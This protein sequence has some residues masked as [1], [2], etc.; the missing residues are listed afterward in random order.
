MVMTFR[1]ALLT[2]IGI[3]LTYLDPEKAREWPGPDAFLADKWPFSRKDMATG[4]D[5][6]TERTSVRPNAANRRHG[7]STREEK[8]LNKITTGLIGNSSL[9]QDSHCSI[10]KLCAIDSPNPVV[11]ASQ[12]HVTQFS[13]ALIED[14]AI[15]RLLLLTTR[16]LSLRPFFPHSTICMFVQSEENYNNNVNGKSQLEP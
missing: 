8:V 11:V 10:S 14:V 6:R 5:R 3:S 9:S 13:S 12:S 16:P 1:N 2:R 15:F 4:S 7:E